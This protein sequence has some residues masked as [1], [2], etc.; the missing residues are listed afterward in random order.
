MFFPTTSQE[1]RLV[2]NYSLKGH[3]TLYLKY[4]ENVPAAHWVRFSPSDSQT[5]RRHQTVMVI[6]KQ[7]NKASQKRSIRIHM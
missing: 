4:F 5:Q 2:M 1:V 6:K 7:K 3:S